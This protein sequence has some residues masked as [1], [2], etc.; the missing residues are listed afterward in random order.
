M[1]RLSNSAH[2]A[3]ALGIFTATVPPR[4][5]GLR[6]ALLCRRDDPRGGALRF[7]AH[8]KDGQ[9]AENLQSGKSSVQSRNVR[10]SV[11]EPI[12]PVRVARRAGFKT[13]GILVRKPSRELRRQRA[14]QIR[15]YIEIGSS[16]TAAEP[17]PQ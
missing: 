10:R 7:F 17:L 1:S 9:F 3:F 11:N 12:S 14:G 8:L 2:T 6:G 16:G 5:A 13:E 4:R 15:A